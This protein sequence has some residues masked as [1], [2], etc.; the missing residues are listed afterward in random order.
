MSDPR[1]ELDR[2]LELVDERRIAIEQNEDTYNMESEI[3]SLKAEIES[4]LEEY[5]KYKP[6]FDFCHD[7]DVLVGKVHKNEKLESQI[8]TL[9]N[10]NKELKEKIQRV[11][12]AMKNT[13]CDDNDN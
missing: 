5:T 7:P 13:E 11:E 12:E 10:E 4:Q 1:S 3:S 6:T 8:T 2:L 9:T